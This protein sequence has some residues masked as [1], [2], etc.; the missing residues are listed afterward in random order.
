M[1]HLR[2]FLGRHRPQ[3]ADESMDQ[4]AP[5]PGLNCA[6]VVDLE[7][8]ERWI[9]ARVHREA[10]RAVATGRFNRNGSVLHE[11]AEP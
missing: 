2:R 7:L 10:E 1:E 9:S 3:S 4:P 11:E 5:D 6:V 8:A